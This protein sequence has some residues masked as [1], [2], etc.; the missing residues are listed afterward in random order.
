MELSFK[1]FQAT[2]AS[3]EKLD[4]N[5]HLSNQFSD[6]PPKTTKSNGADKTKMHWDRAVGKTSRSKAKAK[7]QPPNACNKEEL[8]VTAKD[9]STKTL[10]VRSKGRERPDEETPR[11][12]ARPHRRPR[13]LETQPASYK[14]TLGFV[15]PI[16]NIAFIYPSRKQSKEAKQKL[17]PSVV[18]KVQ[19]KKEWNL[20]KEEYE[21]RRKSAGSSRRARKILRQDATWQ[22][23]AIMPPL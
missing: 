8:R 23:W 10:R 7:K 11:K 2:N 21:Y 5:L 12:L 19:L 6:I 1:K 22:D 16:V 15:I 20:I 14:E 18:D 9:L 13:L 17:L 3:Q 4:T